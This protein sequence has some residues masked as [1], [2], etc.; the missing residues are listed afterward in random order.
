MVWHS[1][2]FSMPYGTVTAGVFALG[3]ISFVLSF[4]T[5]SSCNLIST[6]WSIDCSSALQSACVFKT[7][8]GLGLLAKETYVTTEDETG[9][10]PFDNMNKVCTS[11]NAYEREWLVGTFWNAASKTQLAVVIIT[12]IGII[13]LLI[14]SCYTFK[15]TV[16]FKI[17]S[18]AFLIGSIMNAIPLLL[19]FTADVCKI[20]EG[21]CDES[22]HFCARS[23]SWGS[24][25]WQTLASS[26][27][28]LSTSLIIWTISS[29]KI[30]E[31]LKDVETLR[32][33]EETASGDE[34]SG[35]DTD[36]DESFQSIDI[37]KQ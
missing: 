24:G 12:L 8:L 21:I 15:R 27:I 9:L 29:P 7:D 13:V 28:S 23:C 11:Y 17:T 19:Q 35:D 30:A 1:L 10:G 18:A 5:L 6:K 25:S 14:A 2:W 16:I 34:E 31:D 33:E 20:P 22:Q 26:C 32:D 3:S 37:E 4:I 36:T